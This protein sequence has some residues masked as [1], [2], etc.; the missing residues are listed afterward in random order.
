VK[1]VQYLIDRGEAVSDNPLIGRIV[2]ELSNPEFREIFSKR[3]RIVYRVREYTAE[4]LT[5]FEGHMLLDNDG[6]ENDTLNS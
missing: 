1:F 5:F 3:H 4:I 2:P 6:L